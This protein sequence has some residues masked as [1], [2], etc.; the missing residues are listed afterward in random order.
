MSWHP[1]ED[2]E[3]RNAFVDPPQFNKYSLATPRRDVDTLNVQP[4]AWRWRTNVANEDDSSSSRGYSNNLIWDY[5][6]IDFA[7]LERERQ[8]SDV[9][10][11]IGGIF[12]VIALIVTVLFI[13]IST[14]SDFDWEIPS[15]VARIIVGMLV[16]FIIAI[17]LAIAALI[18]EF[19]IVTPIVWLLSDSN[20]FP[21]KA[22]DC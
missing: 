14:P 8:A 12:M 22:K 2:T 7:K 13:L 15:I 10:E 4:P 18:V 1:D 9:G 6:H 16:F 20:G 17:P 3:K 11:F 5:N 21:R 19:L